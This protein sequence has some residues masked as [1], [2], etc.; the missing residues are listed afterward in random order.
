MFGSDAGIA[1]IESG[2][3]MGD[4]IIGAEDCNADAGVETV[5]VEY[6]NVGSGSIAGAGVAAIGASVAVGGQ[7]AGVA[8]IGAAMGAG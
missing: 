5:G 8:A 3:G 1:C 4:G 7:Y 2:A 6:C